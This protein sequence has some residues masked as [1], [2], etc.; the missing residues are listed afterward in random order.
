MKPNGI[1]HRI[2]NAQSMGEL[3]ALVKAAHG[4]ANIS[5]KTLRKCVKLANRRAGQFA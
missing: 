3:A 4:F 2:K 1:K 5:I